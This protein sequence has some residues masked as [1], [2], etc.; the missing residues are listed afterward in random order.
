MGR[1]LLRVRPPSGANMADP[2]TDKDLHEMQRDRDLASLK[3]AVTEP[4]G[5]SV[6]VLWSA[7]Q[8]AQSHPTCSISEAIQDGFDEW[9]K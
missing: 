2:T 4:H 6:E 5:L 1:K 9:V 3:N 7:F 8:Y